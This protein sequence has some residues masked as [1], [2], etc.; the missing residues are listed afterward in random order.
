MTIAELDFYGSVSR[1]LKQIAEELKRL[2]ENMEA[3]R[4]DSSNQ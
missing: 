1:Y 4:K 2:N 3:L